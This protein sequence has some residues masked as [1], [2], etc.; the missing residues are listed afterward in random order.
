MQ[1]L[2]NAEKGIR[3]EYEKIV[4]ELRSRIINLENLLRE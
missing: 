1:D 2:E 4:D 3:D